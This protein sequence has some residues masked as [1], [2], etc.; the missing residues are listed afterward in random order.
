MIDTN[1]IVAEGSWGN[2]SYVKLFNDCL[3]PAAQFRF[4]NT[5]AMLN[6]K[7][8]GCLHPL[9]A[10]HLDMFLL[11]AASVREWE[12]GNSCNQNLAITQTSWGGLSVQYRKY[13]DRNFQTWCADLKKSQRLDENY[14]IKQ[15]IGLTTDCND[16]QNKHFNFG[17]F[18]VSF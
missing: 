6:L 15:F 18:L 13:R 16:T 2:M 8:P 11:W 9:N 3:D 12:L 4:V 17:K 1:I 14:G 7:R 5:S 10:R